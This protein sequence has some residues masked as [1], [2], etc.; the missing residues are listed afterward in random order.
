MSSLGDDFDPFKSATALMQR[1]FPSLASSP[2]QCDSIDQPDVYTCLASFHIFVAWTMI[3]KRQLG[4]MRL[5]EA[6][7]LLQSMPPPQ[8]PLSVEQATEYRRLGW[9]L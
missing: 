9:I 2:P 7:S 3:S 8:D 4:W 6:I 1:A 5:Q